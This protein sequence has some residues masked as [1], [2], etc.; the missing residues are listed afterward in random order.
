[1]YKKCVLINLANWNPPI[2]Q[3][4]R[5]IYHNCATDIDS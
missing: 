4:Q 3:N 5:E 1:M 2:R